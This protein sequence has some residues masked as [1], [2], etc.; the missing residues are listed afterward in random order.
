MIAGDGL[1]ENQTHLLTKVQP[2]HVTRKRADTSGEQIGLLVVSG[3][4][5]IRAMQSTQ[6][7]RV[8]RRKF[9]KESAVAAAGM[10]LSQLPTLGQT[11]QTL[12][13]EESKSPKLSAEKEPYLRVL[14]HEADGKPLEKA[15]AS[16][17][18]ARDLTNDPLPQALASAEGRV[19]VT[20]AK[21]PMQ[22]SCRLK[23]PGFGE[24]YCYADN[25]GKGFTKQENIEFVV[26]AAAT[27]LRRVK[28]RFEREKHALPK[29]AEFEKHLEAA[30]KLLSKKSDA[31]RIASA[32]E[33]L[34]HGLH[35]GEMLALNTARHRIS[36][37]EKP[38]KEFLFGS[39]ISHYWEGGNFTKHFLEAFNF[40]TGSWYT[41]A[42]QP[43]PIE[44]R[45]GYERMDGAIQWCLDNKLV[46]RSFGYVYMTNGATPEWFRSWPYEKILPEYKRIVEMTTRRYD[47]RLPYVEVINEAHDKANLFRLSHAQIL[48]LTREACAAAR[49]GSP[50]VKRLINNCC[51]WA[52]HAKR[53]NED[54]SRRWSPYMYLRDCVKAGVE[55]DVVGLQLYYPQQDLFELERM[56]DRFK[57]FKKPI[58]ITEIACNSSDGLDARSMGA[59][60]LVP[61]WHGPW[62]ETMQADWLEGVYTLLYSKPEFIAIGWWDFADYGG[63]F[64][65]FGGLL[66]ADYS[67]KESFVRLLQLQKKWG[68]AKTT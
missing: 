2:L 57:D 58:F 11:D 5:K 55:F 44:K 50:T 35:A 28:E 25:N 48:E 49:R 31:D 32:Y 23:V 60:R 22:I 53:T 8:P 45:I 6:R 38:R 33:S 15:R 9:L 65:P 59:T 56:L 40:G 54:G 41:W 37:F 42:A 46:P 10:A 13:S 29:D 7:Q 34:A 14:L 30:A 64:W 12:G 4:S 21:V 43:D 67:P 19:R 1:V 26:E 36:K 20:L 27:R 47:G 61:G 63:H 51:L 62:T 66:R 18:H 3:I 52:E 68:V 39:A 24:V 16:T 17:L